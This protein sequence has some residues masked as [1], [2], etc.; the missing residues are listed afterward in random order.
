ME[1]IQ[2][3]DENIEMKKTFQSLKDILSKEERNRK[4]LSL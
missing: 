2:A 3:Q 4:R 1:D